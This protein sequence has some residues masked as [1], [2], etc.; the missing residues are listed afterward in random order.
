MVSDDR[1]IFM[2]KDGAVAWDV[3]DYLVQQDRCK[4]VTIEGKDY[5][6]KGDTGASMGGVTMEGK[7]YPG[8]GDTGASMG[9]GQVSNDQPPQK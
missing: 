7:D 9:R 8:N 1:A 2:L 5:P 6:G 4:V 3:K